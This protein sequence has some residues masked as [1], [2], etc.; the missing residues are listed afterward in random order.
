MPAHARLPL[1]SLS[2]L[3]L[4]C[5]A[6]ASFKCRRIGCVGGIAVAFALAG[7]LVSAMGLPRALPFIFAFI[8]AGR[9]IG[10]GIAAG[11]S[12]FAIATVVS[13]G[14]GC[15]AIAGLTAVGLPFAWF[16][17]AALCHG[18]LDLGPILQFIRA[19]G[20]DDIAWIYPG[21]YRGDLAIA[22]ADGHCR[23][24]NKVYLAWASWS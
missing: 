21:Q 20:H 17:I 11:M 23:Q 24:F 10:L 2:R 9:R 3:V 16:F 1:A 22:M 5:I 15:L 6:S 4:A 18:G 8:L 13:P 7:K 12:T 14:F 19:V